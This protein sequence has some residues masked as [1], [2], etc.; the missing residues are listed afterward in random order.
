VLLFFGVQPIT[1]KAY[2]GRCCA[3][4]RRLVLARRQWPRGRFALL[5]FYEVNTGRVRWPFA[6][7]KDT[8]AICALM[9]RTRRWYPVHEVWI[10]LGQDPAHPRKSQETHRVM[11]VLR[12]HWLRL[13]KASPDDTP[14]ETLFSDIQLHV[15]EHRDDPDVWMTRYRI[16]AHWRGR[17]RRHDRRIRIGYLEGERPKHR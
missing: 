5:A 14:V 16:S 11:R 10:G 1:V 7:T 6:T 8:A 2:G 15:L 3:T 17:N 4:A 12:L 9:W 13:L